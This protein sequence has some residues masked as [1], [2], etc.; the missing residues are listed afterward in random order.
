MRKNKEQQ[1]K[2]IALSVIGGKSTEDLQ[3]SEV[4]EL[5]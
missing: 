4:E 1:E 3:V 2:E 5:L